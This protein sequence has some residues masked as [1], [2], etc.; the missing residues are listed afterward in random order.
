M[1]KIKVNNS[2]VWVHII[3]LHLKKA[4]YRQCLFFNR[5]STISVLYYLQFLKGNFELKICWIQHV[6]MQP[7]VFFRKVEHFPWQIKK[8]REEEEEIGFNSSWKKPKWKH[9]IWDELKW[10]K[11]EN[12]VSFSRVRSNNKQTNKQTN[13]DS[14]TFLVEASFEMYEQNDATQLIPTSTINKIWNT[15]LTYHTVYLLN[16]L[17]I[18]FSI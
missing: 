18:Y 16:I 15:I 13:V 9:L 1:S 14:S 10:R 3:W 4:V 2:S 8:T 5:I 12:C 17:K 6:A 11:L 7:L